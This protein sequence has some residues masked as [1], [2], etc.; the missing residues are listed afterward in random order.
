MNSDQNLPGSGMPF[1]SG[2]R[3]SVAQRE[4]RTKGGRRCHNPARAG[5]RFCPTHADRMDGKTAAPAALDA[6]VGN[7]IAPGVGGLLAGGVV[8]YWAST[9]LKENGEMKKR[10]FVSFDFDNDKTLKDFLSSGSR[11]WPTRRSR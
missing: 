7:L 1:G 8:G 11:V 10:V 3:G 2:K 5:G 6:A 9:L 4:A